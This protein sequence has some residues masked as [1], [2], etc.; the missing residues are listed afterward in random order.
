MWHKSTCCSEGISAMNGRMLHTCSGYVVTPLDPTTLVR[1][2][3]DG[4]HQVSGSVCN[5]FTTVGLYLNCIV[6]PMMRRMH[7]KL[8][9]F[10]KRLNIRIAEGPK[11]PAKFMMPTDTYRVARLL[12]VGTLGN[13]SVQHVQRSQKVQQERCAGTCREVQGRILISC[14]LTD[15]EGY[16]MGN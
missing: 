14:V 2:Q 7:Y 3:V 10:G 6:M 15:V 9:W 1:T 16:S 8:C 5:V 13:N 4:T 11:R 12:L